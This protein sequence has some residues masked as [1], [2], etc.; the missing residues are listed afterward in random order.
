MRFPATACVLLCTAMIFDR[1]SA[2]NSLSPSLDPLGGQPL[3]ID[4]DRNLAW[5]STLLLKSSEI[6]FMA[7]PSRT[8]F[9]DGVSS[10]AVAYSV[11]EQTTNLQ[12][13]TV[14]EIDVIGKGARDSTLPDGAAMAP[15]AGKA[16]TVLDSRPRPTLMSN[17]ASE[18]RI[19]KELHA[20]T[21]APHSGSNIRTRWIMSLPASP[22]DRDIYDD[23]NV[24]M[25]KNEFFIENIYSAL[26][27]IAT[28]AEVLFKVTPSYEGTFADSAS[29][30]M[31]KAVACVNNLSF[32]TTSFDEGNSI[33]ASSILRS[34][35]LN[36]SSVFS[37]LHILLSTVMAT[38]P[39]GVMLLAMTAFMCF[40]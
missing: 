8:S 13:T 19:H 18:P 17:N 3:L 10:D 14:V 40:L 20:S 9:G 4:E 28:S 23:D 7:R 5:N 38:C 39:A 25:V 24:I 31:A 16:F 32:V 35:I 36:T 11:P 15:Y 33:M 26:V 1:T 27:A 29:V 2:G 6:F 37:S 34:T 21:Q 22:A 30:F 12:S